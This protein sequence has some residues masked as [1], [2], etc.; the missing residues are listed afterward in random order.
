MTPDGY[1]VSF[2][3]GDKKLSKID[4]SDGYTT[5]SILKTTELYALNKCMVFCP[6]MPGKVKIRKSL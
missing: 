5:V 3:R 4:C 2:G 6:K 1:S